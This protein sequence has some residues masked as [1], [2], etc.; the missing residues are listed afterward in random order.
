MVPHATRLLSDDLALDRWLAE[1]V[2]KLSSS[3]SA[4]A[5]ARA[6][7]TT[8]DQARETGNAHAEACDEADVAYR[9]LIGLSRQ[10]ATTLEARWRAA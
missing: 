8:Y 1:A 4:R 5:A 6:W 7:L 3:P 10:T 9:R 2:A